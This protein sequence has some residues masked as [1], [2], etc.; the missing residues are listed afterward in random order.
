MG[1]FNKMF[2]KKLFMP[3]GK[4]KGQRDQMSQ[5]TATA[6]EL[7]IMDGVT[8][9][10]SEINALAS[11]GV[12]AAEMAVLGGITATAA[13]INLA[14]ASANGALMTPGLGVSVVA[15]AIVKYG[16][17]R[18]GDI[19]TTQI[20]I[21]LTGLQSGGAHNDIFGDPTG[22]GAKSH[23]GQI[24][25]A[26]NGVIWG[27]DFICFETPAGCN[28]DVDVSVATAVGAQDAD[29]TGL[30][31]YAQLLDGGNAAAFAD[32][33]QLTALPAANTYIYLSAGTT[34]DVVASAGRFLLTLHGYVA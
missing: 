14:D 34:T 27:G 26:V 24:T 2:V 6:T 22:T 30:A 17:S 33:Q 21:D 3:D 28:I 32:A 9:S 10:T 7:N 12:S 4:E 29:V 25:T 20:L 18:A 5:V 8:A 13:E 31:G 15:T 1:R 11:A 23:F 16:I 19:I